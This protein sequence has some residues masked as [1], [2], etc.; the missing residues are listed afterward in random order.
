[1]SLDIYLIIVFARIDY[2]S[3]VCLSVL[4]GDLNRVRNDTLRTARDIKYPR[5]CCTE[6]KKKV[7]RVRHAV[8]ACTYHFN[9]F[10]NFMLYCFKHFYLIASINLCLLK[11]ITIFS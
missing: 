11:K 7:D 10:L 4:F 8:I 6:L 9:S 3:R 5:R 1:M 2:Q